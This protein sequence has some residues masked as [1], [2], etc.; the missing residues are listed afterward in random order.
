MIEVKVTL[1]PFG[2]GKPVELGSAVIYNNGKGTHTK[3]NYRAL[4]KGKRGQ[5]LRDVNVEDFPRTRLLAWDL[6]YRVLRE[7][8]GDRN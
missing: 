2:I 8:F 1:I 7:A 5:G 4:I 3:G 6:L